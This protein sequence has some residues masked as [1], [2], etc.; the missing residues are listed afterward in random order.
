M[1]S[2]FHLFSLMYY[3]LEG[4]IT[5]SITWGLI[6]LCLLSCIWTNK[7]SIDPNI[8]KER[9]DNARAWNS[10]SCL[11]NLNMWLYDW[12]SIK[13]PQIKTYFFRA[14][15]SNE[16]AETEWELAQVCDDRFNKFR[17]M[18]IHW[19]IYLAGNTGESRLCLP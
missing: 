5:K 18:K 3:S 10:S 9:L 11:I 1:Q 8:L 17:W 12:K 7:A 14:T 19:I 4:I 13:K 16:D 2:T 6:Y 15:R